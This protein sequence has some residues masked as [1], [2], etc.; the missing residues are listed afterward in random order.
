ML[1]KKCAIPGLFLL[2]TIFSNQSMA[3]LVALGCKSKTGADESRYILMDRESSGK[4]TRLCIDEIG[5]DSEKP[6]SCTKPNSGAKEIQTKIYEIGYKYITVIRK[7][8][9]LVLDRSGAKLYYACTP[10][11]NAEAVRQYL[12]DSK[13]E[14]KSAN[15]F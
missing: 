4:I 8:A 12:I 5:T 1:N 7:D 15:V 3:D 9:T 6:Y 13:A 11:K 14:Q 10:S 2:L